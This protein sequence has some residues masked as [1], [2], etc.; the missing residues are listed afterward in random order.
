MPPE[1]PFP[2][3]GG[4]GTG[5]APRRR[6]R[7]PPAEDP[8][9]PLPASG[10]AGVEVLCRPGCRRVPL[11]L[12]R[13]AAQEV[14]RAERRTGVQACILLT[15]DPEMRALNRRFRGKSAATDVLS[16]PAGD[17]PAAGRHLGDGVISVESA[18]RH[19]REA[20]W[21]LAEEVQFLAVHGLLHLLGYDH[22]RDRGAM[23]LLQARIARRILGREI[24]AGRVAPRTKPSRRRS[25]E[26]RRRP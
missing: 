17:D 22:E 14:L 9:R 8:A 10:G 12:V 6:E 11:R 2:R 15:R 26:G 19:A 20:G 25:R 24:P 16:F 4:S 7:I 1:R 21:R 13:D 18:A 23:N 3:S 5:S